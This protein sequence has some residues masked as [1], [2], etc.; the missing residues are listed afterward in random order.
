MPDPTK[1]AEIEVR[2]LT[3]VYGRKNV[4]AVR[5]LDLSVAPGEFLCL[6]G[7]TGC[8]KSTILN[9]IAGFTRPTEGEILVN[10][11]PVEEPD[12]SR[13]MVFQQHALFPWLTVTGNI[14]F[15]PLSLGTSRTE[16]RAIAERYIKLMGLEGFGASYS[17][18]LSGG[19]QQRVGLARVLANDPRILL[20]DEPFGALDAQTRAQM[21]ELLLK[22]WSGS[23]KTVMFV[24]HDVDEAIFL[25]DR[26]VVLTARPAQIKSVIAVPLSRPRSYD[27]VTSGAYVAIKRE[28]L[29]L[30]REETMHAAE[31]QQHASIAK[32][33]SGRRKE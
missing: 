20:M 3:V 23:G 4:I 9:A 22:I 17:S 28:V 15:G 33:S 6:V 10:G 26:I 32:A 2:H 18:E 27:I 24:T 14:Q 1:G 25:A 7:T 12:P 8:G 11:Q 30:I 21:Q 16:S 19:M 13:G 5:Q 31:E 29:G